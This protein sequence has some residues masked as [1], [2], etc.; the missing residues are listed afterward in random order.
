M[1]N[2][3]IKSGY[4]LNTFPEKSGRDVEGI[5]KKE[6]KA[7]A[8]NIVSLSII[9]IDI[10]PHLDYNRI[11]E[12]LDQS[13]KYEEKFKLD[14]RKIELE[15]IK[16]IKEAENEVEYLKIVGEYIEKNPLILKY[17]MINKIDKND[18]IFIPSGEI[19]F[20]FANSLKAGALKKF[21]EK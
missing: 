9:N 12:L 11:E 8:I 6:L 18:L 16:R 3:A 2:N 10:I 5:L 14:I 17:I 21:K 7:S 1:V 19:G 13:L 20:D 4:N 15:K